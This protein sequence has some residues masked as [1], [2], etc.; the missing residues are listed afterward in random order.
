MRAL[1]LASLC[2]ACSSPHQVGAEDVQVAIGTA[3][4]VGGGA[5]L[6]VV[7]MAN[8]TACATVTKACT[9]YPCSSGAVSIAVGAGCPLPLGE[10]PTG[11]ISVSGSWSS[12]T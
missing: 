6:A 5:H 11:T 4:M 10:S 2:V 3:A 1:L 12:A 9:S 7:G 8:P